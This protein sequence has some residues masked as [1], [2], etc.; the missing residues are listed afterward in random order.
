MSSVSSVRPIHWRKL[1]R[2]RLTV[3]NPFRRRPHRGPFSTGAAK[4][5]ILSMKMREIAPRGLW[6]VGRC[7]RRP[8]C[9]V[10]AVRRRRAGAD[11]GR[12]MLSA[13]W[14]VTR[15][16][17]RRAN[18]CTTCRTICDGRRT[19][20]PMSST[21]RRK[22]KSGKRKVDAPSPWNTPPSPPGGEE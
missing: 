18:I 14:S 16:A 21:L 10:R 19:S 11:C 15:P 2:S 9:L 13:T 5:A 3:C 7:H 8:S 4:S 20:S 6:I 17:S 12:L 1:S 22:R